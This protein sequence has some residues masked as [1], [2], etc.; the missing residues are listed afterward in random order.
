M[1]V[2]LKARTPRPATPTVA[3]LL[4]TR[5]PPSAL[6]PGPAD[7]VGARTLVGNAAVNAAL[8]AQ[9][10]AAESG[11]PGWRGE[12]LLAGQDLVG[13]Q[14]VAAQA[15]QQATQAKAPETPPVRK[16]PPAPVNKATAPP[17]PKPDR[18]DATKPEE[19]KEKG[20]ETKEAAGPRAPGTDPKFQALKQDVRKKKR[21]VAASHPPAQAEAGAAQAASVP[22][23]DDQ[24]A[25][26]KVAHTDDMDAAQPKEFDKAEFVRSVEEAIAKRAPKNLDEADKF[27]ESGKAAEVKTEVAGK[28][29]EGKQAS[30]KEIAD[31]TAEPPKPAP[32]AKEVVPMAGDKVPGKPGTPNPNQAAP[33]ALPPSA[34]D[35]SAGPAQVDQQMAAAN[36]TEQ[37]LSFANAREPQFDK[38]VKDKFTMEAHSATAPGELRANE[39]KEIKQVKAT[40][41]QRG[42][43][44]M[45]SMAG[46]RVATGKQ[47]GTGKEA[48]K[49]RDEDKR[50]VVTKLLQDLFDQ[51]KCDVE[52]IL[53]DLDK[54]VDDQFTRDEKRAR[55]KFT[56]EHE[57]GMREYKNRR[58]KGFWGKGRWV[59]D[60]FADLPEEANRIYETA[61]DHYLTAMRQVITDIADTIDRE[62]RRAKDRIA[63]GRKDLTAAV[64]KLPADLKAIG[65]EAATEFAG[66]FDELRD[67]V[68][69][70]GTEL[71][72]TLA[73][74]Y[75]DAVKA[76]DDEIAAE[77]E[78]NKGLV[79][80]AADAIGGAIRTIKELGSLL[81][82]VLRKAV[83]AIGA[84]LSDPIGFLGNLITGVGG[85][86]KLFMKNAGRHLEA[87]VIAWLLGTGVTGGLQLPTSFDILGILL[88]LA[89]L[90]GLS[91]PNLR[92]RLTR[93]VPPQAVQAAET[94]VHA[95]PIVV[96]ANKRGVAGLWDDLKTRVGDLKKDLVKNLVSFLLPTIIIAGVTWIVSLFN[97]ASAFIRA[98]KMIIDIVRFIVTQGRQIIEFVNVVLDAVIA[99]A[100]GGTGGVPA[101]VENALARSIPILIGA[102]AAI[103]GIGGIA[104]KVKDIFQKMARPVNRAIDWVLDKIT[105]LLKKLWDKIKPKKRRP[106]KSGKPR[107]PLKGRAPRRRRPDRRGPRKRRP[108]RRKDKRSNQQ[109]ELALDAAVRDATRLLTEESASE[110]SVRRGLPAIKR[111]HR[112][113]RIKLFKGVADKYVVEVAINPKKK[114]PPKPLSAEKFP[115]KIVNAE[116]DIQVTRLPKVINNLK[117]IEVPMETAAKDPTTGYVVN[118]AATPGEIT[119]NVATRYLGPAWSS[120]K[121]RLMGAEA[122]TAVV[123]G[124]NTFE[125]LDPKT[126]KKGGKAGI[127]DAFGT[128]DH[129]PGLRLGVFG[130]LWTPKWVNMIGGREVTIAEVRHAYSQLTPKEQ[131]IAIATNESGW[132]DGK[133]PYGIFRE[134]VLNHSFTRRA[135]DILSAVNTVVHI[136]SQDADT[137]VAT[138]SGMGVLAAY[139]AV[140]TELGE[141]PILT[142]GG[143]TFDGFGWDERSMPR[144]KQLTN[145]ANEVDRAIRAAIA[146]KH[147]EML[148]PTEP[149]L[150]IKAW[151]DS[152][153]DGIFQDARM[154]ALL[155]SGQGALFGTGGTEGRTAKIRM[156][157]AYGPRFTVA[158]VP[159]ASTGTSPLPGVPT[160]KLS[161]Y[162]EDIRE[163]SSGA[164]MPKGR[165]E[166]VHPHPMYAVLMQSQ[167]YAS[168]R[169]LAREFVYANP[170]LT[171]EDYTALQAMIF[172]QV[173]ETA[174]VMA[175]NPA[176]TV[177]SPEIQ[178][179]LRVLSKAVT[180]YQS[181]KS[182]TDLQ[183]RAAI[184]RAGE[185]TREIITAMTAAD[186]KST[187][188]KLKAQL[189]QIRHEKAPARRER[190]ELP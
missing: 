43:A 154:R 126:A 40:A 144:T 111:T 97:P 125:R 1:P 15:G 161:V 167:S 137:D 76:V 18:K 94:G 156:A 61:R 56:S 114:T 19:G 66:K 122:R 180:A 186:L 165:A 24:E 58:Y 69:D 136:V 146:R 77:K 12:M 88:M 71:V 80:K 113:N 39:A 157:E 173:E 170:G 184:E 143:Y 188:K 83:S 52:K 11:P 112:L 74:K 159:G 185:V 22:P 55:D 133:L 89:A 90:L 147:P 8:G 138:R 128:I 151:D 176:L 140:L 72:D 46:T 135:V 141:H 14:A 103:L 101:L 91:W 57:Q 59:K 181:T 190:P 33:D 84:I 45:A 38:A 155:T 62:L 44:A 85:G 108:D 100:R 68:N 115:Y 63:K 37:Q 34:T 78:K 17:V 75:T 49:T 35:M 36:V 81:M 131:K 174:K 119:S 189:R 175:K 123:I 187:W 3:P 16:Q 51:T 139:D 162:P 110:K 20:A 92:G 53:T 164:Q 42:A 129:V 26:G 153:R 127:L 4:D 160:R 104:G 168:A 29:G 60:L 10:P 163:Y 117:P 96:A 121:K 87:G 67:T 145:L 50:A 95:I 48:T 158:Y 9:P 82:G 99:I 182:E 21:T 6:D 171:G 149:N 86:L 132:R 13:N 105:G 152:R 142:I 177:N 79:S 23:S 178:R 107:K 32:D 47:V 130:F 54:T 102:L 65:R 183:T 28:V 166:T 106:D 30:A 27:G 73:T 7:V 93:K 2:P 64:E 179:R 70:K 98:C 134:E 120:P 172:S 124:V 169:T 41:A 5:R 109:K 25:R 116:G 150:L 118:M 148:Y 31:T